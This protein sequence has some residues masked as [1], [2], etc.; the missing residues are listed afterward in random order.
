MIVNLFLIKYI[1]ILIVIYNINFFI[2]FYTNKIIFN[3][4]LEHLYI[5]CILYM[6]IF[7][8]INFLYY[9]KYN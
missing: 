9:N 2:F 4:N 7:Y 1:T 8:E 6:H 3:K 5:I